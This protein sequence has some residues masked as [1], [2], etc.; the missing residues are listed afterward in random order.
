MRVPAGGPDGPPRPS[1][2]GCRRTHRKSRPP[3]QRVWANLAAVAYP[4]AT[5]RHNLRRALPPWRGATPRQPYH[6]HYARRRRGGLHHSRHAATPGGSG[7]GGG[8]GR[9]TPGGVPAGGAAAGGG[10]GAPA[11]AAAAAATV[12]TPTAPAFDRVGG[13]EP[14]PPAAAVC[15]VLRRAPF[16]SSSSPSLFSPAQRLGAPPSRPRQAVGCFRLHWGGLSA[17]CVGTGDGCERGDGG[18]RSRGW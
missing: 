1:A 11:A 9:S 6:S 13:R 7:G 3:P 4:P 2:R 8:D 10:R 16:G 5:L 18:R 17:A 14:L 12:A 15:T